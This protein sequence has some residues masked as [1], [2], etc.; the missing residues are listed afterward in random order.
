MKGYGHTP[1]TSNTIHVKVKYTKATEPT[2]LIPVWAM[3]LQFIS[4]FAFG[5]LLAKTLAA[6]KAKN[7][8][9]VCSIWLRDD[10]MPAVSG[11]II[12]RSI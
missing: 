12:S 3:V 4:S 7:N 2:N 9:N 11:R 1:F 5:K 8:G 6:T 10:G